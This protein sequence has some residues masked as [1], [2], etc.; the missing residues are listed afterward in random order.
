MHCFQHTLKKTITFSG[1][2]LHSAKDV[3][4]ELRPAAPD[5]GI[6]FF[7]KTPGGVVEIPALTDYVV[8]TSLAT[9]IGRDG[10]TVGTVEHL[11]AALAGLG[12]DNAQVHIDGPEVPAMDGSAAPFVRA[13]KTAGLKVQKRARRFIKV[14]DTITVAHGDS[15]I[16]LEPSSEFKVSSYI[17]FDH[18]LIASQAYSNKL[19]SNIFRKHIA[20]ARTFGLLKDVERLQ[21]NGFAK[22]G[23]LANA[24]VVGEDAILNE[25][26][27]RFDDEFVRHKVLDLVGDLYL[28]G[29]PIVANVEA[30]KSGHAL[31]HALRRE[32]LSRSYLWEEITLPRIEI[33][34][35]PEPV[36]VS[37]A[38][39]A[40]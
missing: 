38:A 37:G 24:V 2:G 14:V 9:T 7:R 35:M 31:H 36:R 27:L 39:A 15:V 23:S 40:A 12:V 5:T 26:G 30:R 10:V 34:S 13:I 6:V 8:D 18:P 11:M 16:T 1:I 4:M 32:L 20:K 19:N 3:R 17:E 21:A 33:P 25:G 22:G 29:A 28:L